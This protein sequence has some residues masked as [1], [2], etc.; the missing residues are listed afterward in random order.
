MQAM[1]SRIPLCPH[2]S[3]NDISK[4]LVLSLERLEKETQQTLLFT[5]GLRCNECNARAGGVKNSAHT[6]GKAV[7]ISVT[8][9]GMRYW[10]I[11]NALLQGF[12]RIGIGHNIIHL[13]VDYTL[14]QHVTW[15]Y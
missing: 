11:L 1:L 4:S 2:S 6:R 15:L 3:V 12:R 13:D 10:I 9:S 14:P 8:T 5:S 7:D